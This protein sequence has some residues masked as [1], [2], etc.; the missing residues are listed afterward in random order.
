MRF[1]PGS[2]RGGPWRRAS[3]FVVAVVGLA[4]CTTGP[5][6]PLP[7]GAPTVAVTM[8]EYRFDFKARV[9]AGRVLFRV[10]NAGRVDHQ[11]RL[12]PLAPGDPPIDALLH[13]SV[14]RTFVDFAATMVLHPGRDDAFV[15]N[16]RPDTRYAL[17]CLL[18][19]VDDPSGATHALLGMNAEFRT[20][21]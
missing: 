16:L 3:G 15:V 8:R 19:D 20:F 13:G 7:A 18:P 6:P 11:L 21:S 4:S 1:G 12:Y 9:P 10:R 14:Q 17:V 5:R 2:R